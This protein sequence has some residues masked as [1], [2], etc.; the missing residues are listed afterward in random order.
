VSFIPTKS[1]EEIKREADLGD[2]V[3]K[4]FKHLL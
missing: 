4:Q 1:F 3:K 2:P